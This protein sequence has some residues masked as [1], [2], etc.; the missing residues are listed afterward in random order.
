[1]AVGVYA[2]FDV[3]VLGFCQLPFFF[4]FPSPLLNLAL[5][6]QLLFYWGLF[7]TFVSFFLRS[8]IGHSQFTS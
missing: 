5:E 8:G 2:T 3:L 6:I 7:F 1:M 4:F